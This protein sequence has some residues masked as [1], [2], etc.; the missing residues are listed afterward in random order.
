MARVP[1]PGQVLKAPEV[2]NQT[3]AFSFLWEEKNPV[4]HSARLKC[5]MPLRAVRLRYASRG[6]GLWNSEACLLSTAPC[7]A[8]HSCRCLRQD[9]ILV[10]GLCQFI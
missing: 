4:S 7:A 9:V 5:V 3:V 6:T 1:L 2:L 8:L 10:V